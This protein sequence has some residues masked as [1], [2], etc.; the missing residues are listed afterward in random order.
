[1]RCVFPS[2]VDDWGIKCI[3]K[4][5]DKVG[6]VV[7]TRLRVAPAE[8]YAVWHNSQG[9]C[10][11]CTLELPPKSDWHVEHVICFNAN[12][13][14][15]DTIGTVLPACTYCNRRKDTK[16]LMSIV[17][18]QTLFTTNLLTAASTATHLNETAARVLGDALT[19]RHEDREF[20]AGDY[21]PVVMAR[22][23]EK[24]RLMNE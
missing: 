3:T 22:M 14:E 5:D 2:T 20:N 6:N 21:N 11:M 7:T 15:N 19:I 13:A 1:M 12:P 23:V 16:D 17:S 9:K 18:D 24:M 4:E 10:Y 8:R